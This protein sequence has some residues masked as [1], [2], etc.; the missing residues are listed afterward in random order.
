MTPTELLTLL[1]ILVL[2]VGGGAA[3]LLMRY[4]IAELTLKL[5]E[6]TQ[7]IR[8]LD[9]SLDGHEARIAKLEWQNESQ[10]RRS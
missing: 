6:L 1:Q 9:A 10:N 3:V 2:L 7:A 5:S 4:Q 8:A